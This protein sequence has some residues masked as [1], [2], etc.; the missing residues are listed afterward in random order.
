MNFSI[1]AAVSSHSSY[2]K[3]GFHEENWFS[4][5]KKGL[6][7]NL[8]LLSILAWVTMFIMP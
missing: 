6:T 2:L 4:T 1:V 3:F 8:E 7:K 5:I